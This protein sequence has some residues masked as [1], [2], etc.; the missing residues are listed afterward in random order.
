MEALRWTLFLI[1]GAISAIPYFHLR[2]YNASEKYR[3]LRYFSM[4]V[5]IW[6]I[7]TISTHLIDQLII[8]YYIDL[9]IYPL[10]FTIIYF[11]FETV[12]TF[13]EKKHL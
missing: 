8:V 2:R 7:L 6:T 10:I 3:Q 11:G 12:Q 1:F 4:A 13:I 9:L 5:F